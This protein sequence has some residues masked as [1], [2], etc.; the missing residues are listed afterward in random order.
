MEH[1]ESRWVTTWFV[2]EL[3][4][5]ICKQ[6]EIDLDFHWLCS[7]H[8]KLQWTPQKEFIISSDVAIA[9]LPSRILGVEQ[10]AHI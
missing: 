7:I 4:N 5:F 10:P 6:V 3:V 1:L 2:G 8:M 9:T